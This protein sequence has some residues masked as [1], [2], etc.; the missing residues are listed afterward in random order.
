M[1]HA[2]PVAPTPQ[3]FGLTAERVAKLENP[4][5]LSGRTQVILYAA[6]V[7]AVGVLSYYHDGLP[8][9][10]SVALAFLLGPLIGAFV[11]SVSWLL[12]KAFVVE[13]LW[14]RRQPDIAAFQAFTEAGEEYRQELSEWLRTQRTWWLGLDGRSFER[15]VAQYYRERGYAVTHT[16]G[17]GDGGIDLHLRKGEQKIIVQC[18]GHARRIGPVAV[19]EIFGTLQASGADEGWLVSKVGFS[20]QAREFAFGKPIS[21]ID[22]AMLLR[23]E[24]S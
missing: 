2:K 12:L 3:G 7:P 4:I 17:P 5:R 10:N 19:R 16:G 6:W 8:L 13:P 14:R 1:R 20:D 11:G 21:L 24:A 23:D 9:W 22:V 15:E 18:R